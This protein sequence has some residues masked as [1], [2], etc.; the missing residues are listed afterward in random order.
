MS[1]TVRMK[2]HSLGFRRQMWGTNNMVGI[3][4]ILNPAA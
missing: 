2:S 3:E 1:R 4:V